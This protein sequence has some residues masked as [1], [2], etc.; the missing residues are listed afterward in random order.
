MQTDFSAPQLADPILSDAN[1]ILRKCVR[2]GFCTATCPS[3]QTTLNELDSPRGRIYLIKQMLES[4]KAPSPEV[5]D[6]LDKCLGC[7][8]CKDR[9]PSGLDY[10][11]LLA[12]AHDHIR[13]T[14]KRSPGERLRRRTLLAILPYPKRMALAVFIG[15]LFK[16]VA[17]V[18][19]HFLRR[20]LQTIP[21]KR[22]SVKEHQPLMQAER[23]SDRGRVILLTG[24]AQKAVGN[25]INE[26]TER[27]LTR[28]GYR[29]V[30]PENAGCCG[31]LSHHMGEDGAKRHMKTLIDLYHAE[32]E[33]GDIAGIVL[34]T[35]GCGST[36]K[37]YGQYFADDPIYKDKAEAVSNLAKD[38]SEFVTEEDVRAAV[39]R[40]MRTLHIAYQSP[41]S[42]THAQQIPH[43]AP[44]LLRAAGFSVS[45]PAE[46][47]L[48]CGSA[49]S[50]SLLQPEIS[51]SLRDRK[52]KSLDACSP[53]II[54]SGNLGCITQLTKKRGCPVVHTI[55]LLDWAAG[56]QRPC[57]EERPS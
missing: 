44:N 8:A 3:Y 56:G 51:D 25:H 27:F 18:F 13:K 4:G 57:E 34:S 47:G 22:Q 10:E 43:A 49:G 53:D 1:T 45:E 55:E 38:V 12:I 24:C 20:L 29:I 52:L 9:C 46:Q 30:K 35:S 37:N 26:A 36:V 39:K 11:R 14:Y 42:L 21:D 15:R 50:F 6:H 5:V 41:C 33:K 7:M 2:C 28:L 17:P 48:C 32:I 54:A 19:P 23:T 40:D 31:A 16:P